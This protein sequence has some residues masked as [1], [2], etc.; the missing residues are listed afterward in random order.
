V[1]WTDG[2]DERLILAHLH[3]IIRRARHSLVLATFSLNE[4]VDH[5][6]LLI[7]PLAAAQR[8]HEVT[9]SLLC[10]ARNNMASHRR[11]AAALADLGV[12]IYADQL[13]HA[14]GV[15]ADDAHGAL[16]SANFDA[17]HGLL[18]GVEAGVRLD[19]QPALAEASRFFRHAMQNADL[20]Y[21]RHPTATQLDAALGARWRVRWP[22]GKRL[23]VTATSAHWERF[24]ADA[25]AGPVLYT[26]DKPTAGNSRDEVR[27]YAGT[28]QWLLSPPHAD[29]TRG[30]IPADPRTARDHAPKGAA[31]LLDQWL[32]A[33]RRGRGTRASEQAR[34]FCPAVIERG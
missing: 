31:S 2:K 17:A 20:T 5:P 4:L 11:D 12:R 13:N 1:I 28:S 23:R 25:T 10:R 15:I 34:G 21:A 26:R 30:L 18:D 7:E 9:A 27:L 19:G 3:D 6:E 29:G 14:K 16:F 8:D 24:R 22:Y 33:P 32:T